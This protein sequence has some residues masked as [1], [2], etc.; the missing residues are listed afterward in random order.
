MITPVYSTYWIDLCDNI[1]RHSTEFLEQ[2]DGFWV[3]FIRKN[4]LNNSVSQHEFEDKINTFMQM[5]NVKYCKISLPYLDR[6]LVFTSCEQSEIVKTKEGLIK[7]FGF[8][9][10]NMVWEALFESEKSWKRKEWLNV[11]DKSFALYE[12]LV[13]Q[14]CIGKQKHREAIIAKSKAYQ[15]ILEGEVMNRDSMVVK[16]I[17]G[18]INYSIVSKS[19]FVIMP[20]KE[21]WS[22]DTWRGIKEVCENMHV[23]VA[24]A[25]DF[26]EPGAIL[27]DIWKGILAAELIIADIT[28]YNANVFYELGIAHTLGKDVV[29]IRQKDGEKVPFDIVHMRYVEYGLLPSQ[30]DKFREQLSK[31]IGTVL[32]IK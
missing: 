21:D 25:D 22:N 28:T 15:K 2:F 26:F 12:K 9:E 27:T 31:V 30:F 7:H 10:K 8:K 1:E 4:I 18:N 20:F 3:V 24:R 17:F 14:K 6:L 23:Q 16:P 32:N 13:D 19:V 5:E 29:M 11:I